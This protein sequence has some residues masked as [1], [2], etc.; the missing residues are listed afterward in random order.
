MSR[1]KPKAGRRIRAIRAG[2]GQIVLAAGLLAAMWL[3][4]CATAPRPR[5]SPSPAEPVPD[6]AAMLRSAD[7][8]WA[9]ADYIALKEAK[10]ILERLVAEPAWR[11][12]AAEKYIRTTLAL[13]LREKELGLGWD[14]PSPRLPSALAAHPAAATYAGALELL[15]YLPC[16]IKGAP[17]LAPQA[18][19]SL[20]AFFEWIGANAVNLDRDFAA[21]AEGDDLFACLRLILRSAFPFKFD[22]QIER[23]TY[24]ALH[25]DSRLV[26]FEEAISPRPDRER[27][28]ILLA[29][30]PDFVEANFF[31]GEIALEAGQLLTAESDYKKFEERIPGSPTVLIS[32]ASVAF[33]LEELE[34][35]LAYDEQA[36]A[37]LPNYRDA[38]LGKAMC[39]GYLGRCDEALAVLGRMLELGTYYVG[40]AH[41]WTAWNL[42]ELG[43]LEEA[44]RSAETAKMF[45][46]G[47]SDVLTLSGII[48]YKQGRLDDA[49]N[50]L[51]E[52]LALNRDDCEAAFHLAR[53]YA[54]R[55]EWLS[56]GI[57]FSGAAGCMEKTDRGIEN[58]IR[59]VRES[60]MAPERQDRLVRKKEARL[61]TVRAMRATSEYNGAAGMFNAGR[62]AEAL[63]LAEAAATYPALADKAAELVKLIRASIKTPGVR[64][65]T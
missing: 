32:L 58:K 43:R 9:R 63:G 23:G 45:L 46:V 16:K 65:R 48:A 52:S 38:L 44:W 5:P 30:S 3:A 56:S 33:H 49:E 51:R 62:P 40:E 54:D 14:S 47:Q 18:G 10:G 37:L 64:G 2:P 12:A 35:C 61:R 55:R 41:Y 26:A 53:V 15:A 29:A 7:A 27:L 6:W 4:A 17:G 57:Y 19:P 60:V 25:P 36:L 42:N 20:D 21:R 24:A 39:L 31:L 22:D 1:E 34:S 59:E 13:A 11:D 28:E 8:L 50:D